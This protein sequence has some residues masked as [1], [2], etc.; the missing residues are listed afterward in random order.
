MEAEDAVE[1]AAFEA[2]NVPA[3]TE[4]A[5][6]F[7]HVPT[8]TTVP[9]GRGIAIIG[10]MTGED[11]G[12]KGAGAERISLTIAVVVEAE[13]R[14]PLRAIKEAVKA[15]LHGLQVVRNGWQLAFSYVDGDGFLD[16][17]EGKAYVGNYRFTVLAFETD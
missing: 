7:Q 11:L 12:I 8:D 1:G 13:E 17:E 5:D 16:P 4:L 10:D 15:Q 14:R 6:V 2:L 3:V 9:P